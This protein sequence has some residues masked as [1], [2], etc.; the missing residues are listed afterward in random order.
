MEFGAEKKCGPDTS[1]ENSSASSIGW[2]SAI[3]QILF[4]DKEQK[5]SQ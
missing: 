1:M 2:P 4:M 3:K 5:S